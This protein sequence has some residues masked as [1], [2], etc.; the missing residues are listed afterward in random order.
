VGSASTRETRRHRNSCCIRSGRAADGVLDWSISSVTI[1][2][3]RLYSSCLYLNCRFLWSPN[4]P[5]FLFASLP[6]HQDAKNLYN[7]GCQRGNAA[8]YSLK[9][10]IASTV[11]PPPPSSS[12]DHAEDL[13]PADHDPKTSDLLHILLSSQTIPSNTPPKTARIHTVLSQLPCPPKCE[14]YESGSCRSRTHNS[15]RADE[16]ALAG[17]RLVC[18]GCIL[19]SYS[20]GLPILLSPSEISRN[21]QDWYVFLSMCSSL[22][23]TAAAF[24]I[25]APTACERRCISTDH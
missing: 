2:S 16:E 4:S 6:R 25:K 19:G 11:F 5:R 12:D 10:R 3:L 23:R 21:R 24:S 20:S 8:L 7:D 15:E 18:L 13:Y 14:P 17:V 9:S 1:L 22:A